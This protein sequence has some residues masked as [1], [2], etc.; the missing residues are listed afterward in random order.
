MI[1]NEKVRV[2]TYGA[3]RNVAATRISQRK[4]ARCTDLEQ[5][6]IFFPQSEFFGPQNQLVN[7]DT[8]AVGDSFSD[9]FFQLSRSCRG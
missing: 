2:R 1:A 3:N 8:K 6:A 9:A 4:H 7:A 5:I